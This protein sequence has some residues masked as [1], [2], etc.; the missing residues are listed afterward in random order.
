MKVA[1]RPPDRFGEAAEFDDFGDL[2]NRHAR[3]W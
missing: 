1:F 3:L 2:G